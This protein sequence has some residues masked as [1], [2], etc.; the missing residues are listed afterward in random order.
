MSSYMKTTCELCPYSRTKTLYLHPHRAEDFAYHASNRFNDFPCHKTAE[1][2]EPDDESGYEGGFVHGQRSKT[3]H[4]FLTLQVALG[5]D[6]PEGFVADGDG[7][8][9]IEEMLDRH[10]DLWSAHQHR[11]RS[12]S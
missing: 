5:R 12:A 3:C 8:E 6:A 4:G 10:Y 2:R 7:F 11:V 1:H 9:S